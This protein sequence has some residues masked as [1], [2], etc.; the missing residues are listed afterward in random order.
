MA[1]LKPETFLTEEEIK[2]YLETLLN[3]S[4]KETELSKAVKHP[5]FKVR[6]TL[7]E[8]ERLGYVT[9]EEELAKVTEKGQKYYQEASPSAL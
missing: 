9:L 6:S 2:V 8:L 4:L 5:L 1:C 7:R 3:G